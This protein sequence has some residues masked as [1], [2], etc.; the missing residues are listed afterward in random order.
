MY[1][2]R[3]DLNR[4]CR[5]RAGGA[6]LR[7][8]EEIDRRQ[9]PL[10]EITVRRRLEPTLQVDVYEVKLGDEFL[11]SSLFTVAEIALADLAL[12]ELAGDQL[13]VVVGGL[14]LGYTASAVLR[15]RRVRSVRVVEALRA[16]IEWHHRHLLPLASEITSDPRCQLIDADFFAASLAEGS[17]FGPGSPERFHALLVD[18]D[19]SPRHLLHTGHGAFY[20]PPGLRRVVERLHPGG[21]FALWSDGPPD[22][23]F[24]ADVE[25]SFASCV[26]HIVTFPNFY[27]GDESSST[28]YV[29][30]TEPE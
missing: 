21:V 3:S 24:V 17:M 11:M 30:T 23:D 16:V 22:D 14:G 12:A 1:P 20:E 2:A 5:R 26:A 27:T 18:I 28:V 4:R 7:H 10:G 19:H 9:T 8:F 15:D 6:A 13:D 29:A 25:G